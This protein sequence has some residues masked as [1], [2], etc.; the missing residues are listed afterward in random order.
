M[1]QDML[2]RR[3]DDIEGKV[4]LV[5]GSGNVAT[6]T[7]EKL[8]G[9][10]GIVVTMSDSSGFVYDK[11][12]ID[13]AKLEYIID[14]KVN[15]RGRLSEYADEYAVPFFANERPWRIPCDLA[16]PCA[17]Q[18]ELSAEDAEVLI[19]NGCVA[20]AEGANMPVEQEGVQKFVDANV[21]FAPSKAA[22]AGGVA[23]SGLE[24][25]QNS[26]RR[27]WSVDEVHES[28]RGIMHSI[29]EQCVEYGAQPGSDHI[30]YVRG[31]NIAGFLKVANAMVA[32]GVV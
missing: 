26:I 16:F 12:G 21:S 31:A 22:N 32:F 11:D 4:C 23:I 25:S 9:L 1:M 27:T 3:G 8:S 28:L 17:T 19:N 29:H 13:A 20:V 14:L 15:R 6:Y 7:A 10:G 5:S 2:T 24:M 18:N 30:D